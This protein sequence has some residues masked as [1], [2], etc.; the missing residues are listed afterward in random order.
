MIRRLLL[1]A[2]VLAVIVGPVF[3]ADQAGYNTRNVIVA[4]MDGVRYSETFG[5]PNRSL[6]PK[7]AA[8]EKQGT[9]FTDCRIAGPGVSVTRQGH[10]TISTGTWQTVALGGARMTMPSFSEYARN[11]LGWKQTDCYAIFGKGNYSYAAYSSFP[12]YGEKYRPS[13]VIN[14]GESEL[15]NDDAVLERVFGAMDKD[16]PRLIFINFGYTDH[17]AHVGT[18]EQHQESIR[19][20]DE[21]FGKLWEK[22][23]STPGYKDA[24][25]VFFTND[26]GRHNDKPNMPQNGFA[27]H[28]DQC[29]GCRHIMLL[30]I[31]PDIKRGAVVDRPTQQIDICPTVGELLGFQTPIAQGVVLSDCIAKPLDLNKKTAKT[32]EA[33]E[34]IRLLELSKR[35]MIKT[36]S[37]A[38]LTRNPDSLEPSLGTELLMRGMLKAS[39][40]TSNEACRKY[41]ASWV[42]KYAGSVATDPHAARVALELSNAD[43]SAKVD[44]AKVRQCAEKLAAGD[45]GGDPLSKQTS[46]AFLARAGNLLNDPKLDAAART[47]LGLDG[48]TEEQLVADWQKLGVKNTPMACDVPAPVTK[49]ASME[50]AL[51]LAA[52]VDAAEATPQDR[53]VR[54]ACELQKAVCSEGRPEFGANWKDPAQS[55]ITIAGVVD[56]NQIK[57][58]I[59]WVGPQ[60]P[61][62]DGKKPQLPRWADVMQVFYKDSGPW[63]VQA[64]RYQVDEKGHYAA[65]DP[66]SD[67]AALIMFCDTLGKPFA[68]GKPQ[69]FSN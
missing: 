38:N 42:D 24:T 40:I 9:L 65:G 33:K 49:S 18:F 47:A 45:L 56:S 54:L 12:T 14:I 55:A 28:G 16:K 6:I 20:C 11:E 67:G 15:K 53:L 35:D 37:E 10:S 29:E 3:A 5:D 63:Q 19:H 59:D 8:L 32:A 1:V 52:L 36:I 34:G 4:V 23:Q 44:L 43:P 62:P 61:T 66:T 48:K 22:V 46:I 41:V 31:G 30:A 17:I 7:L 58:K 69:T 21:M 27:S 2:A 60:Q 64:I 25:T 68:G 39:A 13:F 51:R 50:D 26:H 57:P